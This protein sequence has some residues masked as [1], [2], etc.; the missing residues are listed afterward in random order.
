MFLK[1]VLK[2]L[3]SLMVVKYYYL[4]NLHK[5]S[6]DKRHEMLRNGFQYLL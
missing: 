5:D 3:W 1:L 2:P 4:R 6:S